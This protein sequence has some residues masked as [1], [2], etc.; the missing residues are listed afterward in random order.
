MND[1]W[2]M[3]ELQVMSAMVIFIDTKVCESYFIIYKLS[4]IQ[5]VFFILSFLTKFYSKT[6]SNKMILY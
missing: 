1:E 5:L 6:H 3:I 2:T 4:L